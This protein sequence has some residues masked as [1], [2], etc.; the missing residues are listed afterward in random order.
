MQYV[1]CNLCGSDDSV[2]IDARRRDSYRHPEAEVRAV[3]CKTCGLVYLNPRLDDIE[4]HDLYSTGTSNVPHAPDEK[5]AQM[6]EAGAELIL[7]RLNERVP[8]H[9]KAGKVLDIGCGTGSLLGGFQKRGWETYG[10]EPATNYAEFAREK[11][12]VKVITDF[13]ENASLPSYYFDII[14]LSHALEHLPDPAQTLA[15]ARSLLKDEGLIFIE[16][17]NILK[18]I[19]FRCFHSLHLYYYSPNTLS[20]LLRKTGFEPI[21]LD[22]RGDIWALARK[23]TVRSKDFITE[24]DDYREVISGLRWRRVRII[25]ALMRRWLNSSLI[26]AV[27]YSIHRIFGE[28]RGQK[29]LN[30]IKKVLPIFRG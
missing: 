29:I 23:A 21:E 16:V 27:S 3:I 7:R 10:I 6:K 15:S 22:A 14:T 24:G 17:P 19:S 9:D 5:Y 30:L 13:L 25:P 8:L 18:P 4:R 28:Q 2:L 26:R 1:T 20:L 11:Y 12:G